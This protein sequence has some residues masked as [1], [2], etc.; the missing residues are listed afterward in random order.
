MRI[1]AGETGAFPSSAS[2]AK[3]PP[4]LGSF[5]ALVAARRLQTV[6]ARALLSNAWTTVTGHQ[7][8]PRTSALLT[9]HWALETDGGRCMP[10]YNFA[11]IKAAPAAAGKSFATVEGH[12]TTRQ[13][14][15][16]RFRTYESAEAGAHDYVRLLATRYPE[17]LSA[18]RAGDCAGFA[19]AL[20][21]GGYF[22]AAP[23]SYA[24]GLEQRLAALEQ[25]LPGQGVLGRPLAAPA[26]PSALAQ[27]A[28]EGVLHS[29]RSPSEEG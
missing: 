10:G 26:A 29:L 18:A 6:E 16:A 9:A 23:R 2:T 28:L 21:R 22:T 20:A 24:A 11:G 14:V 27:L 8:E 4:A 7:P 12:G 3:P 1:E 17:A 25:G 5:A 15:N 13:V 19:R